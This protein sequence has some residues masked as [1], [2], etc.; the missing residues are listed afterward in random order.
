M[1]RQGLD[2]QRLGNAAVVRRQYAQAFEL[3]QRIDEE[4]TD[5]LTPLPPTPHAFIDD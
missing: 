4:E 3:R 2:A 1:S 5:R